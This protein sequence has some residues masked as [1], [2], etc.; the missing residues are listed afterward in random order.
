MGEYLP[1][2][3]ENISQWHSV[4]LWGPGPKFELKN[5]TMAFNA[6][7]KSDSSTARLQPG[8]CSMRP[9]GKHIRCCKLQSYCS[10]I[11]SEKKLFG[12]AF[13]LSLGALCRSE[14]PVHGTVYTKGHKHFW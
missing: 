7:P 2:M 14:A 13:A 4:L 9:A 10:H 11:F 12:L 3:G 6:P 5:L 1:T 8:R